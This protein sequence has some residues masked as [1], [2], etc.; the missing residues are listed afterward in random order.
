M[1]HS[2]FNLLIRIMVKVRQ[3]SKRNSNNLPAPVSQWGD[4][5]NIFKNCYSNKV[6]FNQSLFGGNKKQYEKIHLKESFNYDEVKQD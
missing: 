5:L 1:S 2:W 3:L 4:I 6:F